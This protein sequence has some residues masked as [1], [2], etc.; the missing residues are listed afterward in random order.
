MNRGRSKIDPG[1]AD[2]YGQEQNDVAI[3]PRTCKSIDL[4]QV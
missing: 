1:R 3:I 4:N 2:E